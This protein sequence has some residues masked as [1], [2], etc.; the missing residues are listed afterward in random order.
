MF[1]EKLTGTFDIGDISD[2]VLNI[3]MEDEI[4][5]EICKFKV[6]KLMQ[7]VNTGFQGTFIDALNYVKRHFKTDEF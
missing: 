2:E 1:D 4:M 7:D 3:A 6:F 5:Q